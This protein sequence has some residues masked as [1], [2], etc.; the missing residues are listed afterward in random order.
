MADN[1]SVLALG[2]GRRRA[3]LGMLLLRANEVVA[4]D[5]LVDA[6]WGESPPPTALTALH[7]QVS[8]LRRLLG[9]DRLQT[10]PPG[11]LL[12]VDHEELDLHRFQRLLAQD[13]YEEALALWRGPPLSDL[14]FESFAQG[15]IARLDELR[16]AALERRFE[17]DLADGRHVDVVG[18]L[19]AALREHPL[20]ERFTAQ[21]MLALYRAGRQADALEAFQQTRSRLVEEPRRTM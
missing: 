6:L 8:R 11:Y 12:R 10:R 4:Q 13:R 21:L 20:R 16:L 9:D 19:A 2:R 1:G 5:T 15:E 17:R 7:G 3:L 14:A 18:P